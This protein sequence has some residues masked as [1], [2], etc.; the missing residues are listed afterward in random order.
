MAQ[1]LKALHSGIAKRRLQDLIGLYADVYPDVY[2][3][4]YEL[5]TANMKEF[6]RQVILDNRV[7][8]QSIY[9]TMNRAADDPIFAASYKYLKFITGA[10]DGLVSEYSARWGDNIIKVDGGLSHG[11]IIDIMGQSLFDI[12]I[13]VIEG[14]TSQGQIIDIMGK[15]QLETKVL[16]IYLDIVNGLSNRGF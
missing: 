16:N 4:G 8:F 12:E 6:N 11:Q 14:I 15:N 9:S 2:T 5:T 1:N 7:F 10:N 3:V 13:P